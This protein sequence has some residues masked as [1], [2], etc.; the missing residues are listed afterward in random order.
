MTIKIPLSQGRFALID[1]EDFDRVNE[2]KWFFNVKTKKSGWGYAQTNKHIYLSKGKY[3]NK[4]IY[5]HRF[6]MNA[7]NLVI[8]HINGDTLDNRKCNLRVVSQGM[9]LRNRNSN[10]NSTSK[11]VGVHK[12]SQQNVW[13]AQIRYNG[14][15]KHIGTYKTDTEAYEARL[16]FIIDNNLEGFKRK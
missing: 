6:I 13:T 10:K 15:T 16:K 2:F 11:F 9:N 1:I 7:G 4:T 8:D 3:T 5:L 14:K 12:H